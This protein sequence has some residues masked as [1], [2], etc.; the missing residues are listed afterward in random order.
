MRVLSELFRSFVDEYRCKICGS[1]SSL[2]ELEEHADKIADLCAKAL[3]SHFGLNAYSVA[4]TYS[5]FDESGHA[6]CPRC[7]RNTTDIRIYDRSVIKVRKLQLTKKTTQEKALTHFRQ[8]VDFY[9]RGSL[10]RAEKEFRK[11]IGLQSESAISHSALGLVLG[12]KGMLD[13]SEKEFRQS[14]KLQP[15][16]VDSHYSLGLTLWKKNE[17]REKQEELENIRKS[18]SGLTKSD[19]GTSG[20]IIEAEREFRETIRLEPHHADAYRMLGQVLFAQAR[21]QEAETEFRERIRLRADDEETKKF[22]LA[23]Q[24]LIEKQKEE[25]TK[26]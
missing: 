6:Y 24:F 2:E 15:N 9:H 19:L 16:D 8:G 14:I 13:E 10:D 26:K 20:D 22:L 5:L 1:H 12:N 18:L 25:S 4:G 3:Q 7:V 11:A 17:R 21:F 23:A